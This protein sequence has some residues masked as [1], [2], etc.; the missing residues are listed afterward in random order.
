ML[1]KT[2]IK[3]KMKILSIKHPFAIVTLLIMVALLSSCATSSVS[4]EILV[5]ADISIP[6]HIKKVAVV[7]RSLPDKGEKLSNI[8]EGFFSGESI[9]ADKEGSENCVNGLVTILNNSPRIEASL[10]SYPKL[11][12]TGTREWPLTLDWS[13]VDSICKMY[14]ADALV[15]LETFDS[16]ILYSTGKNIVKRIVDNKE[17]L[18]DEFFADLRVNVNAG[19]RIYD[20]IDKKIVDQQ[21]FMDEKGWNGKGLKPDEALK[22][23]PNKRNAINAAG[24][25]AGSQY[26][27]RISP[28]W[29]HASRIYYVKGK[30]ENGFKTAKLHVKAGNWDKAKIIWENL[31]KS[32]DQKIAGR[33]CYNMALAY[34]MEGELAEALVWAK[35]AFTS[36]N[37]KQARYYANILTVRITE[38]DKLKEQLEK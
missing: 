11:K 9:K 10:V 35:K 21:S 1:L 30:K 37:L 19:W 8:I 34:E 15:A 12:G 13:M 23:L 33:A 7:N 36:Y 29:V 20:N 38:Q 14:N 4:T 22:N 3:N 16:D 2:K 17:V 28:T 27:V 26:G 32:A 5:P 31:S 6:K 25:F 24:V 18:E